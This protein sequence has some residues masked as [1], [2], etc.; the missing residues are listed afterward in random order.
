MPCAVQA[1]TKSSWS[2][3]P[4]PSESMASQ[5]L[6]KEPYLLRSC[7]RNRSSS[8]TASGSMSLSVMPALPRANSSQRP[9]TLP[10]KPH[11]S[12]TIMSLPKERV[13]CMSG[14]SSDRHA[15]TVE[16]C[17]ILRYCFKVCSSGSHLLPELV[18]ATLGPDAMLPPQAPS[19]SAPASET[20]PGECWRLFAPP[21]QVG[22]LAELMT[23][24][25]PRWRFLLQVGSRSQIV[26]SMRPGMSCIILKSFSTS[27][28]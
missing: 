11:S 14:S 6:T 23:R 12:R 13:P 9:L 17:L 25:S 21:S 5:A 16:P 4:A 8:L 26:M 24:T 2:S 27:W 20:A 19:S 10:W 15:A 3:R 28:V 18:A 1:A 7:S 22:L